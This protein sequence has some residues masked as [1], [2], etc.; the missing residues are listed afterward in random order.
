MRTRSWVTLWGNPPMP[1]P[2]GLLMPVNV[3]PLNPE[4]WAVII[5]YE[6]EGYVKDKDAEKID[7]ADLLKQMQK[8]TREANKER[9]KEGNARSSW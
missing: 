2:L 3:G 9:E 5:T 4:S 1:D 6:E 7:Y 8:D